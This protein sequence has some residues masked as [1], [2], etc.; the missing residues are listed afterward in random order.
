MR[1]FFAGIS[2]AAAFVTLPACANSNYMGIP[3]AAGGVDNE[4]QQ[5]A[6]R[7]RS[8][9]K[10][11]LLELAIRFEEGHGVP[12]SLGKAIKLYRYAASDTGGNRT[13][14]VPNGGGVAATTVSSGHL[15]PGLPAARIRARQAA[16]L[17]SFGYPKKFWP[18]SFS[19]AR[20]QSLTKLSAIIAICN[21]RSNVGV[22]CQSTEYRALH[23]AAKL[24]TRFRDCRIKYRWL[25]SAEDPY[26]FVDW[27]AYDNRTITDVRRCMLQPSPAQTKE[28]NQDGVQSIWLT[29]Y[30]AAKF[31]TNPDFSEDSPVGRDFYRGIIENSSSAIISEEYGIRK[32]PQN[33]I[34]QGAD[35]V[36]G[37]AILRMTAHLRMEYIYPVGA[38]WWMSV[39]RSYRGEISAFEKAICSAILRGYS[40]RP[41]YDR[42]RYDRMMGM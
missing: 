4:L 9:D 38:K 16:A 8:G 3:L 34:A 29:S 2:A 25:N 5:L 12:V 19:E 18:K 6:A 10:R 11:A 33:T 1:R 40:A 31:I 21:E 15:V 13:I 39:C 30:I 35:S 24:E 37:H 36:M 26:E 22:L 28:L 17:K 27:I 41:R 7:A 14:F 42:E 32:Y 23:E 20:R